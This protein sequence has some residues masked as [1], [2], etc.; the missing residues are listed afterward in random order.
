MNIQHKRQGQMELQDIY[1]YTDTII[2]FKHLLEDDSIKLIIIQSLCYLVE[3][4]LSRIFGYVIMPNHI[5]LIWTHLALNGKE[6]PA[7][8]FTKF[9]AHQIKK[10]LQANNQLQLLNF[11][12]NKSDRQYQFWKRDQ[13]A[14]PLSTIKT[15]EQK[16]E[17][18]HNNPVVEKWALCD[19]PEDYRRSSA[20]CY[21]KGIDEFGFLTHYK[22]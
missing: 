22:E 15:L 16:L 13:L 17:Y 18:I 4:K 8:S 10:Y 19:Q 12:S 2:D 20:R 11:S 1:F 7:G 5:H 21:L 14:I 6:S 9:T 3:H